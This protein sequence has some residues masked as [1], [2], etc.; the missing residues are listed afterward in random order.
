[1]KSGIYMIEIGSIY[2]VGSTK[3]FEKRFIRHLKGLNSDRH[4]NIILQRAFN[5]YK[6]QRIEMKILEALPY[7]RNIII[8]RE[9]FYIDSYRKE[10]KGRC[11][12]ISDASFGDT[13]TH[14][15]NIELINEKTSNTIRKNMEMMTPEE[16][17]QKFGLSGSKNGMYGKKHSDEV[18]LKLSIAASQNTGDK[19]PFYGKSHTPETKQKLSNGASQRTGN[20]NSFYGK[21]HT[22]E[23]KEKISKSNKDRKPPN[24]ILIEINGKKYESYSDANKELGIGITTI[25]W[26]CLS[27]NEKFKEYKILF[28]LQ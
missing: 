17:K 10:F 1:M 18:K 14:H 4:H 3:N 23:T 9:Q 19:N 25:R 20:K 16:R 24:R 5:K 28:Q 13:R 2:Y 22:T 8:T 11:C 26:R 21:S 27:E 15:P 7:E 6:P 12:N